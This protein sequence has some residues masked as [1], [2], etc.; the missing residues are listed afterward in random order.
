MNS[1]PEDDVAA[2]LLERRWF[3]AFKAASS[4]RSECEDLLEVMERTEQAWNCARARL[5][6]LEQMRDTFG[7]ELSELD[8]RVP[9]L[10]AQRSAA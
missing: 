4:M 6:Q 7:E 2:E 3:A 1:N 10:A 5:C 8:R 9:N